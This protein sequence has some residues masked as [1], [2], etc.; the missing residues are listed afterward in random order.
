MDKQSQSPKETR[1]WVEKTIVHNRPDRQSG[2]NALGKAIWSPQEAEDGK[3][4]YDKML[5][6]QPGDVIFHFIDNKQLD[7]YSIAAQN[8][9]TSFVGITGTD[10][11]GRPAFRVPV[12]NHHKLEPPIDRNEFLQDPYYRPFLEQLLDAEE[13]LFFNRKFNLNQG[14]YLTEAPK[15]LVQIWNDIYLKKNGKP[16]N[17]DWQI[18]PL[19][20]SPTPAPAHWIFQGNPNYFDVDR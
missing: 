6:V 16:L 12:R 19:S 7:S 4:I 10:W 18:S 5:E 11:G 8:A 14:S 15:E 9:D 3:R 1:F 20:S 13:G 17:P 2:D